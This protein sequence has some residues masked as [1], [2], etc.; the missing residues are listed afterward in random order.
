MLV[1][2]RGLKREADKAE[3]DIVEI[4]KTIEQL[5]SKRKCKYITFLKT[6]KKDFSYLE[7]NNSCRD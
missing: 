6:F 2:G 1:K 5:K 7:R 4:E 3:K